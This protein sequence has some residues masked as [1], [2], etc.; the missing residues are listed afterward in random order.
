MYSRR[1]QTNIRNKD[2]FGPRERGGSWEDLRDFTGSI[3]TSRLQIPDNARSQL[4]STNRF[5]LDMQGK[6]T[7][8]GH[9]FYNLQVQ[10]VS[11]PL[12]HGRASWR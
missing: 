11:G 12:V 4:F 2:A 3:D 6:F 7:E 8:K 9:T 5:R 1:E 10:D